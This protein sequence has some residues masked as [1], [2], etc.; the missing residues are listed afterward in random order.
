M[1]KISQK[2]HPRIYPVLSDVVTVTAQLSLE[3]KTLCLVPQRVPKRGE[4]P[5]LHRTERVPHMLFA[6]EMLRTQGRMEL[7]S[8][9]EAEAQR[10]TITC[11][12]SVF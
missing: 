5:G 2:E 8:D 11:C 1:S 4:S 10:P 3:K 12:V 9:Y 6:Q 7:E